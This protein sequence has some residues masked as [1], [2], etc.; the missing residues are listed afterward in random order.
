M[1]K[2][3]RIIIA[4]LSILLTCI[5]IS[6]PAQ[7]DTN[8]ISLEK[9][10]KKALPD[11]VRIDVNLHLAEKYSSVDIKKSEHFARQALDISTRINY[12]KGIAYSNYQIAKILSDSEFDLAEVFIIKSL[13]SARE[14][15][16]SILIAHNYMLIGNMKCDSWSYEEAYKYFNRALD[17]YLRLHNYSSVAG[18]YNNI[19]MVNSSLKKDSIAISYYKKAVVMNIASNNKEWLATNYLNIGSNYYIMG[20]YDSSFH[21]LNQSLN[22]AQ[23]YQLIR[24][25]PWIYNS[26]TQGYIARNDYKSAEHFSHLAINYAILTHNH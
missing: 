18:A 4:V 23:E 2:S 14:T 19:G 16:D 13:E 10:L 21:Y 25:L 12:K 24:I 6:C 22:I 7:I 11:T 5:H 8:I 17:I 15:N 3:G 1:S 26:F 20:L 9:Q